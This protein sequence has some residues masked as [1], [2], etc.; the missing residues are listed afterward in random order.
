[1]KWI[2]SIVYD[3]FILMHNDINNDVSLC[4]FEADFED[5]LI[6]KL[7]CRPLSDVLGIQRSNGTRVG[8]LEQNDRIRNIS[9]YWV[10]HLIRESSFMS[11]LQIVLLIADS[12]RYHSHRRCISKVEFQRRAEL[13]LWLRNHAQSI[14]FPVTITITLAS[15]DY[16]RNT[17][18]ISV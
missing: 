8:K 14:L 11:E 13:Q 16:S 7:G 9:K 18:Q 15:G 4:W 2:D 5:R 17:F 6:L 10:R 1:M 12:D 3:M